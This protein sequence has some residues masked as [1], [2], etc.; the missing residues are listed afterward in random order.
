[1]T[2]GSALAVSISGL[3]ANA[4]RINV[5]AN[6]IVN[7]NTEGFKAGIVRATSLNANPTPDGGSGVVA[8]EFEGRQD[9]NIALEFIRLIEA[10]AAYKAGVRV[11][12]TIE[13]IE[14]EAL[15]LLA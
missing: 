9:V 12:Q 3:Q 2:V 5:A 8:Q 13:E 14:T 6:N 11:I 15:N 10:E 1:M 4:L 7:Q